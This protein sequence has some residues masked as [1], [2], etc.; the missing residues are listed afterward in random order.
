MIDSD[1]GVRTN[2]AA[3]ED[4]TNA[5]AT[6]DDDGDVVLGVVDGVVLGVVD[7]VVDGVVL[8]VVD[9]VVL[10][11]V[12]GVVDGV[13]LGVVDGVVLGVVDGVVLGVVDGVVG[14]E[15]ATGVPLSG[16][17]PAPAPTMFTAFNFT[18]YE[19]PFVKPVITIGDVVDAG[20]KAVNEVPPFVETS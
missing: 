17:E 12:D 3:L 13:V 9:G 10:G 8:G 5:G 4:V 19:V 1:P 7:G 20:L 2:V 14:T 6:P 15:G 16:P 18:E 11:V